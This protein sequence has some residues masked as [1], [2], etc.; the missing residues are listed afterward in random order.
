[1]RIGGEPYAVRLAGVAAL[2][3]DTPVTPLPGAPDVLLGVA[4]LRGA[5]VP[6]YDFA[7][8]LG[9]AAPEPGRWL[10]TTAGPVHVALSVQ[11]VEGLLRV[12]AEAI[13]GAGSDTGS[14]RGADADGTGAGAHLRGVLTQAGAARPVVHLPSVLAAVE[15]WS[16]R[17]GAQKER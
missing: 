9:R 11:G 10:L 7:A 2:V 12:P 13:S 16:R 17:G 5:V 3:R 8:L 6:V 1:V 15:A 4:A 14:T